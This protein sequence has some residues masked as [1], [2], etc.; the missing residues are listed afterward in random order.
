MMEYAILIA[1]F[2]TAIAA[3]WDLKTTEIPD[4]IPYCMIG[5]ALGFAAYHS[6]ALGSF[7]SLLTSSISGLA[8]LAFGLSLYY[9]GQWGNGDAW[10]LGAVGFFAPFF[11][12]PTLPFAFN[13]VMNVFLVGACYLLVYALGTALWKPEIFRQFVFSL[14]KREIYI[15]IS[16]YTILIILGLQLGLDACMAACAL[17]SIYP[18]YKFVKVVEQLGFRRRIPTSK[19]RVGDVLLEAKRWDGIKEAELKRIRKVKRYVWIKDGARFA[20][21]FFIALILTQSHG[22]LLLLALGLS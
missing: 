4:C 9:A 1:L 8:L 15:I 14:N 7:E 16:C 11:P 12:S 2:G 3:A 6:Y 20:P 13:Y 18:V 22:N 5:V 17:L 21:V 10:L 19:L